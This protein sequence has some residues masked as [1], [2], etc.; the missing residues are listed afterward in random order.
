MSTYCADEPAAGGAEST[1]V[2]SSAETDGGGGSQET[3]DAHQPHADHCQDSGQFSFER[4]IFSGHGCG[5][6]GEAYKIIDLRVF[7][8]NSLSWSYH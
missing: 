3:A 6:K 4:L 8:S 7:L 1:A 5:L 2:D